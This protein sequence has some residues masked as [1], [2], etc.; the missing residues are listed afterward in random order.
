MTREM[1][2]IRPRIVCIMGNTA[3]GSILGRTGIGKVRGK[4]CRMGDQLYFLTVHPAATLYKQELVGVLNGDIA[5][6]FEIVKDMRRGID[7]QGGH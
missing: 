4:M 7:V 2:A 1:Q 5:R 3:F 6:L